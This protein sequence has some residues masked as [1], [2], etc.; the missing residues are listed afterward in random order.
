M[1]DRERLFSGMKVHWSSL[2]PTNFRHSPHP[3]GS[4]AMD[5]LDSCA[6]ITV[7]RICSR[8][9]TGTHQIL[10]DRGVMDDKERRLQGHPPK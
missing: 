6:Y 4:I 1:D 5:G 7:G 9:I 2:F 8:Q 3:C 10:V